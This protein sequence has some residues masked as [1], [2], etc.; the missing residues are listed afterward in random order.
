VTPSSVLCILRNAFLGG[1]VLTR[2]NLVDLD[3]LTLERVTSKM[4]GLIEGSEI[5]IVVTD[6]SIE[7][8]VGDL[9]GVERVCRAE[10]DGSRGVA[11]VGL[12]NCP[13]EPVMVSGS[14]DTVAREVTTEVDGATEDEDVE[15][16]ALGNT[17]LVEHG[18]TDTRG[19]VNATVTKDGVVVALQALVLVT[20]VKSTAIE[21]GEIRG[22]FALDVDFVVILQVGTNT[23]KIDNDGNVKLLELVGWAHTAQLEQLGRVV[24]STGDDDLAGSSYRSSDTSVAAVLGTGLVEILTVKELDTSSTR[25]SRLVESDLGNVAVG[26][27]IWSAR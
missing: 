12:E 18:S 15:L 17:G 2:E 7:V 22:S 5:F 19:G 8:V 1:D 25:R 11:R 9:R 3:E 16:V 10:L 27:D 14:V 23:G 24:C 4:D 26:P 21:G 6:T 13:G 20:A